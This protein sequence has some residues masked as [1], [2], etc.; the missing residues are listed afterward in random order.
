MTDPSATKV[1]RGPIPGMKAMLEEY[2]ER[3]AKLTEWREH[4]D[5]RLGVL[6]DQ[7]E[8]GDTPQP[9][10]LPE[11]VL[12]SSFEMAYAPAPDDAELVKQNAT[13]LSSMQTSEMAAHLSRVV[14]ANPELTAVVLAFAME[15]YQPGEFSMNYPENTHDS[16]GMPLLVKWDELADF[17]N[18]IVP[19]GALTVNRCKLIVYELLRCRALHV[20]HGRIRVNKTMHRAM[21]IAG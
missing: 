14:H 11:D 4:V 16:A 12:L 8:K 13:L 17:A 19:N 9:A 21:M 2:K 20:T 6:E 18:V 5:T 10:R 3:I 1:K 7:A 15:G